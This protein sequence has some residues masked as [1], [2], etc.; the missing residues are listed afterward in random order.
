M[1]QSCSVVDVTMLTAAKNS[2]EEHTIRIEN[3]VLART[4]AKMN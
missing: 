1:D 3:Y 4:H 2:F